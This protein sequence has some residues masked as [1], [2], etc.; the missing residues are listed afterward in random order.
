MK[1]KRETVCEEERFWNS[2]SLSLCL[3]LT[4]TVTRLCFP[5]CSV[6][7]FLCDGLTLCVC[8]KEKTTKGGFSLFL[9]FSSLSLS[10]SLPPLL[11]LSLSMWDYAVYKSTV[12][13]NI[14][15]EKDVDLFSLLLSVSPLSSTHPPPSI[16]PPTSHLT[17]NTHTHT[18]HTCN[19]H[20]FF[21][22]PSF[23][24]S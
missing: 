2:L 10:L 12:E 20:F 16:S 24:W 19:G 4:L 17:P 22:S 11:S 23:I 18:Q 15:E 6:W 9:L 14:E 21:F 7:L 5:L 3:L 1:L 13:C 8:S